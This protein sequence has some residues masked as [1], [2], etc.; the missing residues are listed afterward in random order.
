M[1][2]NISVIPTQFGV[3]IEF[4]SYSCL[5]SIPLHGFRNI[6][7]ALQLLVCLLLS[8][9]F[10]DCILIPISFSRYQH[11][12]YPHSFGTCNKPLRS[13]PFPFHI[14]PISKWSLASQFSRTID[15][16]FGILELIGHRIIS[17]FFAFNISF[18]FSTN[19]SLACTSLFKIGPTYL[20]W[21]TKLILFNAFSHRQNLGATCISN[22]SV[23]SICIAH[24][25]ASFNWC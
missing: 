22:A 12:I 20:K 8:F 7:Y 4:T 15:W 25:M 6:L 14:I 10:D 3:V 23:I 16:K 11:P 18:R 19:H 5:E 24:S 21:F 17:N 2:L 9:H 13:V 1:K